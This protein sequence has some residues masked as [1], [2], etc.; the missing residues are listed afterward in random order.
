M[1]ATHNDTRMA[2][3]LLDKGANIN[4]KGKDGM[5]ALINAVASNEPEVAQLLIERGADT[6]VV[7]SSGYSA[8]HY[9]RLLKLKGISLLLNKYQRDQTFL[10]DTGRELGD[11]IEVGIVLGSP[12]AGVVRLKVNETVSFRVLRGSQNMAFAL[13]P[14]KPITGTY[15][16]TLYFPGKER[17]SINFT[18]SDDIWASTCKYT[19][20]E[21]CFTEIKTDRRSVISPLESMPGDGDE[22]SLFLRLDDGLAKIY[23]QERGSSSGYMIAKTKVDKNATGVRLVILQDGP[24]KI[25][26]L[27]VENSEES[28]IREHLERGAIVATNRGRCQVGS[29]ECGGSCWGVCER[30]KVKC[31]MCYP[32]GYLGVS[33]IFHSGAQCL[34]TDGDGQIAEKPADVQPDHVRKHVAVA[35]EK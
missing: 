18:V 21:R 3:L 5:S 22:W 16:A 32:V 19:F 9:A 14:D 29:A 23:L 30:C 27:R 35:N 4:A 25:D 7:D 20:S 13:L 33:G 6:T 8:L 1:Y 15:P 24:L 2:E 11:S 34:K 17:A 26:S 10:S 28:H 12:V 31:C